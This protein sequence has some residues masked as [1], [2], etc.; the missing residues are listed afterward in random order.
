MTKTSTTAL[1]QQKT[2]KQKEE[3]NSLVF[4]YLTLRNVIGISGMLLPLVLVLTTGKSENDKFVEHSISE[5]YYSSNGDVF[6]VLMSVLGVF[7]FTYNGY[8]WK[9]K[10]LTTIAAICAI[11]VA[12]SPTA[13][14][15]GNSKSIHIINQSVRQVFGLIER[16]FLFAALFFIAVA[17][18]SLVYFTRSGSKTPKEAEVPAQK[19]KRNMVYRIC[20]WTILVSIAL[21]TVYFLIG[22]RNPGFLQQLPVVFILETIAVEAFGI[23]WITKGQ[24]L[25]P[26]KEHYL[27]RTY[28]SMKKELAADRNK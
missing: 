21:I 4:S 11:G 13:T 25:W 19:K 6:V 17:L 8:G 18:I 16:H 27:K 14:E 24:S 7:L 22:N 28:R 12:F 10:A 26:D 3:D 1:P 23:S 20:G 2:D 9:E 15:T 5:Y